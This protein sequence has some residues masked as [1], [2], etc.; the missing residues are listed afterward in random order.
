MLIYDGGGRRAVLAL[1]HG[2]RIDMARPLAR[3]MARSGSDLLHKADVIVPVPLH[4]RR[5][6]K[7]RY[8]QS[9]ELARCLSDISGVPCVPDLLMRTKATSSQDGLNRIERHENQRDVF[10]VNNRR[11]IPK[12][13]ILIDDV[14]T[15]GATLCACAEVLRNNG[16]QKI[17]VLV[18][19]RVARDV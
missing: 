9:A 19:A 16:V 17:D 10:A 15:T 8:N 3:W 1:K 2:D 14:M 7:R 5:F 6:V 13:V 11:Y 12:R 4:W 18:L